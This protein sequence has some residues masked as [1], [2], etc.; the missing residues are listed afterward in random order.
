MAIFERGETYKNR[1]T[2]KSRENVYQDPSK[3]SI[4]IVDPCDT[5]LL[6]YT[7]MSKI[8]TGIYNYNYNIAAD[9]P[10]GEYEVLVKSTAT[11]GNISIYKDSF[12]VLP[13]NIITQVR[14]QAG[15]SSTKSIDDDSLAQI[16]WDSYKEILDDVFYYWHDEKLGC[17]CGVAN[18]SACC[19]SENIDGTNKNFHTTH[20]PIADHD[21]DGSVLGEDGSVCEADITGYWID[22]NCDVQTAYITVNSAEGGDITVT[23]DDG[24]SAIPATAKG[25]YVTYYSEPSAFNER[26]LRKATTYLTAY[27]VA[28][29][30][31][32]L[33]RATQADLSIV[34]NQA[35]RTPPAKRFLDKYKEIRNMIGVPKMGGC[36]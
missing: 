2:V 9:A 16:A 4:S 18:T 11:G 24:T 36:K 28:T 25:V 15:L 13:W 30:F 27:E 22:T 31:G 5:T 20:R 6:A 7:A 33:D 3:I 19:T 23:Q 29:R 21:G 14:R 10:F 12:F 26:L 32:E 1:T 8:D 34:Q 17:T 35:Y